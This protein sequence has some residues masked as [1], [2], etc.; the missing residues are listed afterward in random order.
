MSEFD[1][2][3]GCQ[4]KLPGFGAAGQEKLLAARVLVAGAGGLGCPAL[5]YLAAAGV[6]NITIVDNDVVSESNLH[7][8]ILYTPADAGK[9]KADIAALA[10]QKQNPGITIKPIVE[11]IAA[12]N[13]YRLIDDCDI[14]LDCTDNFETR[15]LLNDA[16]VLAN[17]P[18]VYGAIYQYEGQAALWNVRHTDGS[19]SPNYRDLFRNA[20]A[21]Q[22]PD[23]ATGGVLPTL[24]GIIGCIQAN[25]AIKYLTGVG[26]LLA[27][28]VW[29]F[30]TLSLQSRTIKLGH[31]TQTAIAKLPQAHAISEITY[32]ELNRNHSKYLLIDVRSAEER[33]EFNIGGM[34]IP[35]EEISSLTELPGEESIVTYCASGKRSAAAAKQLSEKFPGRKIYSLQNGLMGVKAD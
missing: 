8:Q 16:C 27:G 24:A 28:K 13:V 21:T 26:E 1:A 23:C 4:V 3:Y 12:E 5:Q 22:I 32:E 30:D 20:D 15:Y 7:R 25:E 14:I 2:R 31:N 33:N 29:V 35:I 6:G 11:R 9:P 34:H 19:F 18:L 17:K 10:L